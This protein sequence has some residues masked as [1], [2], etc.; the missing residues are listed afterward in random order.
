MSEFA[1]KT[2][3]F[4]NQD[5]RDRAIQSFQ[6]D[7]YCVLPKLCAADFCDELLGLSLELAIDPAPPVEYEADTGYPG[8]PASR[9]SPGGK[10]LRRLR[11]IYDRHP[12]IQQQAGHP[13]ILDIVSEILEPPIAM[14]R[15]HHN[16]VMFKDPRYGSETGWHQDMRYWRFAKPEL[17]T[18]WLALTEAGPDG[19]CLRFV[20]GSHRMDFAADRFDSEQF[21]RPELPENAELLE[22][23]EAVPLEVGDV[24]LFHSRLLHAALRNSADQTRV[25]LIF[26]YHCQNNAPVAGTRSDQDPVLFD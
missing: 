21:F 12:L 26:T 24:V 17:I 11:A 7:G 1:S 14:S 22:S 8:A 3:P 13:A 15:A 4:L 18:A 10:T 6:R 16:C 19:G 9:K 23:A 25:S 5:D 20:P 2:G